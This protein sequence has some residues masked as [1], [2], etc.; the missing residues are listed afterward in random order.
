[1]D[2]I[3]F[4]VEDIEAFKADLEDVAV[5]NPYLAP[6]AHGPGVEGPVR[7]KLLAR[8]PHGSFQLS[9]PDAIWIDVAAV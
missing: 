3:G 7:R 5:N 4:R 6:K 1:M 9:D 2:H 8:C